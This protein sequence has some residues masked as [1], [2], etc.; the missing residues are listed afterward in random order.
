MKLL[1]YTVLDSKAAFFGNP[2]CAEREAAAIRSFSDAVNDGSNPNN[3]WFKHPE[4]FTLYHL[5]EYD[6]ETATFDVCPPRAVVT[7]SAMRSAKS[8]DF[9]LNEPVNA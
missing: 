3:Q 7:A 2:W 5:G 8:P 9:Q 1:I 4:D 6:N